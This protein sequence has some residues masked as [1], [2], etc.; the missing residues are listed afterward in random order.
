MNELSTVAI[1][2]VVY[3]ASFL[4]MAVALVVLWRRTAR[5]GVLASFLLLAAFALAHGVADAIDG[6]LRVIGSSPMVPGTLQAARLVLLAV[7]F[8]ILLV[9]GVTLLISE[10][11]HARVTLWLGVIAVVGLA[12]TLV[13]MY[14]NRPSIATITAIDAGVRHLIAFPGSLVAGVGLARLAVRSRRVG[15]EWF[16]RYALLAAV[17]LIVYGVL[18]GLL[19]TGY[20]EPRTLLGLPIQVHRMAAA[21]LIAIGSVNMLLSL[22]SGSE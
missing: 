4:V 9:F 15:L 12:G 8:L 10:P 19:T 11:R 7:S 18:A 14:L 6:Y 20:P 13:S 16:A 3:A 17:G 22:R 5:A 2:Y 21:V 1:V